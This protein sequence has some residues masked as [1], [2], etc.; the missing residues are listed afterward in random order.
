MSV[1]FISDLHLDAEHPEL[2]AFFLAF[3][4]QRVPGA[5]ALYILGDFFEVWV[6][7]DEHAPLHETV[8]SALR[9]VAKG[10]TT[11][12]LMRGNRDF[13]LGADYAERCGAT[14]IEEPWQITCP[15]GAPLLLMH[16]DA[17]C[18]DDYEYQKF[19]A[20]SRQAAWQK[21]VLSRPLN[22]RQTMARQLRQ[23]SMAKNQGK[24]KMIMD[25]TPAEVQRVM[26]A[27]GVHRLL[28]GHTHRPAVHTITLNDAQPAER[29]VLGDWHDTTVYAEADA[30]GIRLIPLAARE[31]LQTAAT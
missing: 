23:I 16:G 6:G 15:D 25:V 10:G 28:H 11:V 27:H 19:R 9:E 18:I 4:S 1:L 7:D 8:A 17:L 22:E 12:F 3:L 13:L 21:Q 30:H 24:P 5:E 2:T 31:L 29:Y 14:L 26:Q 20:L